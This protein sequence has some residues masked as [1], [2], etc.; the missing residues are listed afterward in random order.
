LEALPSR[1]LESVFE[2]E[3]PQSPLDI[4]NEGE[5]ARQVVVRRRLI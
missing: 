4:P 1:D 5:E 2:R 3:R